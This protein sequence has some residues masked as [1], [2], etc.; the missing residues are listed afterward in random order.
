MASGLSLFATLLTCWSTWASKYL[1][2]AMSADATEA[3]SPP[4]LYDSTRLFLRSKWRSVYEPCV[5]SM[6]WSAGLVPRSDS[7]LKKHA[8]VFKCHVTDKEVAL[9]DPLD[10]LV[11]DRCRTTRPVDAAGSREQSFC[12]ATAVRFIHGCTND[13]FQ[14]VARAIAEVLAEG[15][16]NKARWYFSAVA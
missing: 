8:C 10:N 13:I 5:I 11:G 9:D 12:L 4:G 2:A 3:S 6:I 16:R 14:Y 1:A 7:G 15:Y